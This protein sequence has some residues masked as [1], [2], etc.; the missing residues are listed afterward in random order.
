[1]V[2][3]GTDLDM[4][5]PLGGLN[6]SDELSFPSNNTYYNIDFSLQHEER[7]EY[8]L[9][10]AVEETGEYKLAMYLLRGDEIYRDLHIWIDVRE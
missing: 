4:M 9:S 1:M 6:E 10:F 7:I 5:N 2:G 3:L 8:N